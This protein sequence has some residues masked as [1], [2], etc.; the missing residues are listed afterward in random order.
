M[1]SSVSTSGSDARNKIGEIRTRKR[2]SGE[3][4]TWAPQMKT[5][6]KNASGERNPNSEADEQQSS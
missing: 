6:W 2:G 3:A 4:G 5:T 1:E